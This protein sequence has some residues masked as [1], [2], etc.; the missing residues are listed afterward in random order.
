MH[1][2]S[3]T[4]KALVAN[5]GALPQAIH[6]VHIDYDP[7]TKLNKEIR[8]TIDAPASPMLLQHWFKCVII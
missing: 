4:L 8:V 7:A 1:Q 3:L 6:E 5:K 2:L